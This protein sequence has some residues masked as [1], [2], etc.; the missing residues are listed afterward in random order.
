QSGE[1]RGEVYPDVPEALRRWKSGG[2]RLAIYSS[3]SELAQRRLFESTVDGDLTPLFDGFFDTRVGAKI[4]SA[5][6]TAILS[7]LQVDARHALFISDHTAELRAAREAG[8][9]TVLSVRPGN[10]PQ[11]DAEAF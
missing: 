10:P 8:C 2:A 5:S 1:L 6:Y 7:E 11:A 3:G 4:A 9:E